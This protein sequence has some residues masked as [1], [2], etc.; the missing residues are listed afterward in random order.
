MA[1]NEQHDMT[2]APDKVTEVFSIGASR[3][4]TAAIFFSVDRFE[5]NSH[6]TDLFHTGSFVV[7]AQCRMEWSDVFGR[8]QSQRFIVSQADD[9]VLVAAK[10]GVPPARKGKLGAANHHPA[11]RREG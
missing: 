9:G 5:I 10:D 2:Y 11:E 1:P 7:A 3:E 6:M 8:R 4:E